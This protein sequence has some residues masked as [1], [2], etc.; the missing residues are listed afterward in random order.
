LV[1]ARVIR[2]A[3][4]FTLEHQENSREAFWWWELFDS[5]CRS[6]PEE[7]MRVVLC[8]VKLKGRSN[9]RMIEYGMLNS[10]RLDVF[11]GAAWSNEIPV[12]V[13]EWPEIIYC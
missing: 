6:S 11:N 3:A 4:I 8:S 2:R 1:A 13:I 10:S 5:A 12:S 9:W 7:L